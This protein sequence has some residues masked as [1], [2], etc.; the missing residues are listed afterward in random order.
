VVELADEAVRDAAR[1]YPGVD[2]RVCSEPPLVADILATGL[3]LAFDNAI[4]NA[5]KHGHATRIEVT[6]ERA[7]P[8]LRLGIDDDGRGIPAD[9]RDAV[10]A[11]FY[12]GRGAARD[13]SGLGLALVAQQAELHGGRAFFTDSPLGGVRLVLDLGATRTAPDAAASA[14]HG[15]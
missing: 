12:R 9:E 13:G 15:R 6:A 2:I 8:R 14:P 4:G 11:R 5:V 1:R 3:R 7:G 10:F